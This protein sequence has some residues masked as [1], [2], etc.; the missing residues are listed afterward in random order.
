MSDEHYPEEDG[1]VEYVPP[2]PAGGRVVVRAE[3]QQAIQAAQPQFPVASMSAV[4]AGLIA[5]KMQMIQLQA[6]LAQANPRHEDT[7]VQ[8]VLESC[9]RRE[10]AEKALYS[11][12]VAGSRQPVSGPSIVMAQELANAWG[13]L[14]YGVQ[15][16]EDTPEK[17]TIRAW[18]WDLER[19][20]K[21]EADVTFAKMVERKNNGRTE[22][23]P[24]NEREVVMLTNANGSKA[25]RNMILRLLP[26]SL[27]RK[28][29]A[30][31]RETMVQE[32]AENPDLFRDKL[33]AKF[34]AMGIAPKEIE[35]LVG[36]PIK[37]IKDTA[38]AV[39]LRGVYTRL[40]DGSSSW[41]D[42]LVERA[43]ELGIAEG[44][45]PRNA[46]ELRTRVANL[47]AAAEIG[48]ASCRE[49]VSSP[50]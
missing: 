7:V 4:G 47:V 44:P 20:V 2:Q 26:D 10:F 23:R 25:I 24:A 9:Q 28:A 31:V 33:V 30:A 32:I 50:V 42:V 18:A 39:Y 38:D 27:K 16:I 21:P 40:V 14:I 48:R 43:E 13:N 8:R 36:K 49:R 15:I 17:R 19:N 29:V 5:E 22:F 12:P 11:F 1:M 37:A 6:T 46:A 34:G 41:H 45:A 35:A 3:P